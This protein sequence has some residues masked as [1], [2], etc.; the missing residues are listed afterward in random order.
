MNITLLLIGKNNSNY[1][2]EGIDV[3]FKRIKHYINFDIKIIPALKISKNINVIQQKK[4][5]FKKFEKY[6][7]QYDS[8]ILLDENGKTYDSINFA[9]FIEGFSIRGTKK[10]AFIVGGA[11]GFSEEFYKLAN[12]KISLSKMTFSHQIIRLIFV[13]QLYRAFT[14]IKGEQYHNV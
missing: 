11:Y 14:I 6:L 2:T 3:Y 5:E 1:I 10:L 8:I 7:K 4:L 13:E 12:Y 9:K